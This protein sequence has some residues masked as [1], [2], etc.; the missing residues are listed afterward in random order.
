[1]GEV[2]Q[3]F[4][5]DDRDQSFGDSFP[6]TE[7]ARSPRRKPSIVAQWLGLGLVGLGWLLSRALRGTG[8][9]SW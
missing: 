4:Q 7:Q 6:A 5:Y 1:M 2:I 9:R 8:V 3:L